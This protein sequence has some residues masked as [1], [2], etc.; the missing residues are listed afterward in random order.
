MK[1]RTQPGWLWLF[2]CFLLYMGTACQDKN[3][4]EDEQLNSGSYYDGELRFV[5]F[6]RKMAPGAYECYFTNQKNKSEL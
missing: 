2:L 4:A 3:E 6:H 5:D 1:N